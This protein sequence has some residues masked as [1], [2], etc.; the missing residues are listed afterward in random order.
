MPQ[1][2]WNLRLDTLEEWYQEAN[3]ST[4]LLTYRKHQNEKNIHNFS[5]DELKN[6]E[7]GQNQPFWKFGFLAKI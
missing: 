1:T 4:I 6:L 2:V 3:A 7:K 5:T